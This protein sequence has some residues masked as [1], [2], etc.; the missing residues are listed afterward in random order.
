MELRRA[1]AGSVIRHRSGRARQARRAARQPA[2][3]RVPAV[4]H[5]D[6]PAAEIDRDVARRALAGH[7]V[8]EHQ[9]GVVVVLGRRSAARRAARVGP[10]RRGPGVG[11]V[12]GVPEQA[13]VVRGLVVG[14]VVDVDVADVAREV[15]HQPPPAP[16]AGPQKVHGE[17]G[18]RVVLIVVVRDVG[19]V[20]RLECGFVVRVQITEVPPAVFV[21]ARRSWRRSP[22]PDRARARR[23]SRYWRLGR[24]DAGRRNGTAP[25]EQHHSGGGYANWGSWHHASGGS[26][27][28]SVPNAITTSCVFCSPPCSS[29]GSG[30]CRGNRPSS[31]VRAVDA[32]RARKVLPE[33]RDRDRDRFRDRVSTTT[34]GVARLPVRSLP[35]DRSR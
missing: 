29:C 19:L 11:V 31:I 21:G 10:V 17:A 34:M 14:R 13:A 27:T 6:D 8:V 32:D 12:T 22:W 20:R 33:L 18:H 23:A 5:V 3:H 35:P 24:R 1:A 4:V 28:A 30:A 16:V 2:K 9:A 15:R 7:E 26:D 25:L